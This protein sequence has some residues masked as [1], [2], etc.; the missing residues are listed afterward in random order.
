MSKPELSMRAVESLPPRHV[1]YPCIRTEDDRLDI[2]L[3]VIGEEEE[4]HEGKAT[5]KRRKA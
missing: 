1:Y 2:V 5:G 3:E 4:A